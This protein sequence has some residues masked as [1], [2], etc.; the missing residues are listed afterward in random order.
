MLWWCRA[1][2]CA[3]EAGGAIRMFPCAVWTV[4]SGV[5]CTAVWSNVGKE[6]SLGAVLRSA[7]TAPNSKL[8]FP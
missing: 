1:L 4:F 3:L 8:A 2:R 6:Y 5:V 7:G